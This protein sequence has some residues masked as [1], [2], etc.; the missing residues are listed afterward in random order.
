LQVSNLFATLCTLLQW[1]ALLMLRVYEPHARRPYQI[2]LQMRG[3]V[4]FVAFPFVM[5]VLNLVLVGWFVWVIT[6]AC[7]VAI[8][9][10]Y[11]VLDRTQM[12]NVCCLIN[13][14][15]HP[16]RRAF[17]SFNTPYGLGTG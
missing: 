17:S 9:C 2:P 8:V 15:P 16:R 14:S 4:C 5:T 11:Y 12:L 10:L 1:V 7:I 3:L 6:G 13:S